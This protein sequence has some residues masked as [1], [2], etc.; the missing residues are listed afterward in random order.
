MLQSSNATT[1]TDEH[2]DDLEPE[3]SEGA[4]IE[5]VTYADE[6][7]DPEEGHPASD[8]ADS[9]GRVDQPTAAGDMEEDESDGDSSDTI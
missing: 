6:E 1:M 3:V 8:E 7:E 2:D 4:E 9:A 5:T